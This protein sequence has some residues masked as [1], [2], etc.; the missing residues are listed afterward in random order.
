[1]N[2][3]YLRLVHYLSLSEGNFLIYYLLFSENKHGSIYR[4]KKV[5]NS[6]FPLV[7]QTQ[8]PFFYHNIRYKRHSCL[9]CIHSFIYFFVSFK[10]FLKALYIWSGTIFNLFKIKVIQTQNI[11]LCHASSLY[12]KHVMIANS[13]RITANTYSTRNFILSHPF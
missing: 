7:V 12:N 4:I 6:P 5:G 8:Q 9:F 13:T 3:Q 1:M 10:I 11:F 2:E